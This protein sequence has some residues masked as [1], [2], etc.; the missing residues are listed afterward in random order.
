MAFNDVDTNGKYCPFCGF[1]P[2]C[3]LCMFAVES[4]CG[5]VAC[6]VS[7]SC[8]ISAVANGD[9]GFHVKNSV[10]LIKDTPSRTCGAEVVE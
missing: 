10:P 5:T 2:P 1:A 3:G 6:S 4:E 8:I 7:V 9:Y